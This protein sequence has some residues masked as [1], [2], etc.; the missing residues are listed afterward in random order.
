[1]LILFREGNFLPVNQK[2]H[3]PQW[4]RV[5]LLA[6]AVIAIYKTFDSLPALIRWTGSLLSLFTPVLIGLAVAF[7]LNKPSLYLEHWLQNRPNSIIKRFSRFFSLSLVYLVFLCLVIVLVW[8]ILPM[9]FTSISN[10]LQQLPSY[11]E[12]LK[13]KAAEWQENSGFLSDSGLLKGIRSLS[14]SSILPDSPNWNNPDFLRKCMEGV[15]S[16]SGIVGNIL[17]GFVF[18][19]YMLLEKE[20]LLVFVQRT[21]RLCM[22]EQKYRKLCFYFHKSTYLIFRYFGGQ[23]LDSL[24]VGVCAALVLFLMKIPYGFILG[25]LFGLFNLIPYFGPLFLGIVA[26]LATLVSTNLTMAVWAGVFLITIQQIDANIVNPKILGNVLQISPFWVFLSVTIG[27]GIAGI[28]G[29][30]L[31]VPVFA[32]LRLLLLDFYHARELRKSAGHHGPC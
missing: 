25:I 2:K 7:F 31:G 20:V 27:G 4:L 13:A 9:L 19:F 21:F 12:L 16:F 8:A 29:M 23:L 5:L 1:M 3:I 24:L 28:P 30:L 32:V 15:A 18:S 26:V 14:L 17:L 22:S 11:L 10:F 6:A